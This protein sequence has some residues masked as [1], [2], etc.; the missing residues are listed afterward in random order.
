MHSDQAFIVGL[1]ILIPAIY[2]AVTY[3]KARALPP[4]PAGL[5]ILGNL[6]D[7][8]KGNA[9]KRYQELS[10][11][12]GAPS[13]VC[14]CTCPSDVFFFLYLPSDVTTGSDI[15]SLKLPGTTIIVLSSTEIARELVG[16]RSS[17]YSDRCAHSIL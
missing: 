16:K 7:V 17:I 12:Y 8:P 4:G 1:L 10:R 3:R 6:F 2:A 5:P 14:R 11:Q 9:Y 13:V 15:I